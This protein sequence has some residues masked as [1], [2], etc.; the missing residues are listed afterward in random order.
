MVMGSR[1]QHLAIAGIF[2]AMLVAGAFCSLESWHGVIY[3]YVGEARTPAAVQKN[4]DLSSLRGADLRIASRNRLLSEARLLADKDNKNL[5]GIQLG[6]FITASND[7]IKQFACQSYQRVRLVF[8][9]DGV[10][11]DGEV[12]QMTIEGP[13][14]MSED[15]NYM[16]PL[17]IPQAQ[18]LSQR[19]HDFEIEY[20][21]NDM[22]TNFAFNRMGSEWPSTWILQSALLFDPDHPATALE[23]SAQD[24]RLLRP[25]QLTL[26]WDADRP[27]RLPLGPLGK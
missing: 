12:P 8:E 17:W 5:V 10:A 22:R 16:S 2:T 25:K 27:A 15:V 3:V 21:E 7:G 11:T 1:I 13:C 26:H 4:L 6:H 23:F 24:V 14:Q 9:A 20:E 19:P 18:L